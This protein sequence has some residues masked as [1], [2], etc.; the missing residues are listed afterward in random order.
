[1]RRSTATSLLVA[2]LTLSACTAAGGSTDNSSP[3]TGASVRNTFTNPVFAENFPEAAGPGRSFLVTTPDGQTWLL[4]HAWLPDAIG[5]VLPGR[6]LWLDRVDW[7]DG[8]PVVRGPT[9]G[10]QPVPA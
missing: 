1:V 3:S 7:V 5:S 8:K 10:P 4:Y 2:V 6:Q 9:A